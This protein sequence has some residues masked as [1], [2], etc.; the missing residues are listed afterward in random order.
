MEKLKMKKMTVVLCCSLL[1]LGFSLSAVAA[2][3][4]ETLNLKDVFGVEGKK[5]AV[6]F[7]HHRHQAKVACASCH[8]NP[9]GGGPVK[10]DLADRSGV[11]N[12]FHRKWCWPCHVE[13]EVP[14]GK[15]CT[16]CHSGPV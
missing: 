3:G 1:T 2:S 11:G 14:K 10:F 12:D 9:R 15:S 13:M 8:L 4:P 16:T 5:Q 6:I 7:P